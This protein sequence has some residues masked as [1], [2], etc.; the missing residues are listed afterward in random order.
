MALRATFCCILALLLSLVAAPSARAATTTGEIK[1]VVILVN[2]TDTAAPSNTPAELN[3]LVFG[4][5]SDFY[6]EASYQKTFLSGATFGWFTIPVSTT[7]CTWSQIASEGNRAAAAAGANLSSYTTFVYLFPTASGCINGGG[8]DIGPN[9]EHRV[10]INGVAGFTEQMISH[11]LGHQFGLQHSDGLDCDVS[12][13]GNTC[14]QRGYTDTADTMGGHGHFNAFQKERLGWLNAAGAPPI[15]TVTASGR[16]TIERYETPGTGAKALKIPK[17]VDPASGQKTWYYLEYR[18][19][20]GF[21]AVLAGLGNLTTGVQ[22]RTGTLTAGGI[23]TSLLLDMTASSNAT[24]AY[25]IWDG[26]LGVGRTYSDAAAGVSFTVVSADA[27]GAVVDVTVAAPPAACVRAAPALVLTGPTSA[28]AAGSTASYTLSVS[29]RDGS[30]C[31]ATAF[32]LARSVPTGWS[33]VLGATNLTLSPGTSSS[34]TLTV[35]SSST[36]GA[37]NYTIGAGTSSAAGAVHTASASATY[38]IASKTSGR[39]TRR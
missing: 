39:K 8:G 35:V 30:G 19:P 16:Y 9:G 4:K 18:Q 29:N 22:V 14:V 31:T 2:F 10:F 11:E 33:G 13:L 27:N 24:I 34:T 6:W 26:A 36:A 38:A 5:V 28:L 1:T 25:D 32:A 21:D 3:Q 17:S 12:A 37:A 7:Q 15:T 20:I 23:G